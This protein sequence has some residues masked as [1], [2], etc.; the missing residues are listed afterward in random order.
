MK[1]YSLIVIICEL[2]AM[3]CGLLADN[4]NLILFGGFVMIG[5]ILFD[6]TERH[7]KGD[8]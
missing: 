5:T 3:L 4:T 8:K 6:Y 7:D 2:S 1:A